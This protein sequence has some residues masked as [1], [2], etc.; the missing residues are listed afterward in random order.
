MSKLSRI[1]KKNLLSVMGTLPQEKEMITFTK[2]YSN[3]SKA[4]RYKITTL[5]KDGFTRID[6]VDMEDAYIKL[7]GIESCKEVKTLDPIVPNYS[8]TYTYQYVITCKSI[9]V[10]VKGRNEKEDNK[11]AIIKRCFPH[12]PFLN[13]VDP[14]DMK[15][16]S[17][18]HYSDR[19]YI[20]DG[21]FYNCKYAIMQKYIP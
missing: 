13:D 21:K 4:Y 18:W 17:Y 20:H 5:K 19:I 7:V 1:A 8:Y 6:W 15:K 9:F 16:A 11:I 3:I 10:Y 2:E 14:K 12:I